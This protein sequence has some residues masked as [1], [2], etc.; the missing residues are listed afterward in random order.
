MRVRRAFYLPAIGISE[1]RST[2]LSLVHVHDHSNNTKLSE[3][4]CIVLP[5]H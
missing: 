4:G 3:A 2:H 1:R 5:T